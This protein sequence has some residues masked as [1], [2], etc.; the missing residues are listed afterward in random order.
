V[1][2]T[3]SRLSL[4]LLFRTVAEEL[5]FRKAADIVGVSPATVSRRIAELERALAVQ[6]LVRT[7]RLV[8]L[9]QAGGQLLED[10][11]APIQAL[12]EAATTASAMRDEMDGVVRV[13]T[14]Y[15]LAETILVPLIPLI[16]AQQPELRLELVLDEE[17]IDIRDRSVDIALRIGV[18]T[19]PTLIAR[20]L[21]SDSIYYYASPDAGPNPPLI[22]YSEDI[23][24]SQKPQLIAKD[25]RILYKLVRRGF[26]GAWLPAILCHEDELSGKLLRY[27]ERGCHNFTISLVYHANRFIPRRTLYVM[28]VITEHVAQRKPGRCQ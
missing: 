17:V 15:T 19:D 2:E 8:E 22:A 10:I 28:D 23:V 7:T 14:T 9:T 11:K 5:S 4:L 25:M 1:A 27:P 13:A 6:L 21:G 24:D 16:H 12:D 18:L 20:K 26:G 3:T